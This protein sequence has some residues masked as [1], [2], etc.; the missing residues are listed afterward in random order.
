MNAEEVV[1]QLEAAG[2]S[3]PV[4]ETPDELLALAKVPDRGRQPIKP[5]QLRMEDPG[6]GEHGADGQCDRRP[7]SRCIRDAV[8]GRT[9]QDREASV[10]G[11]ALMTLRS[12]RSGTERI[13]TSQLSAARM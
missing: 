11:A 1:A 6:K 8:T 2:P 5:L 12:S 9:V 4:G 10:Q 3:V 7:R 13:A